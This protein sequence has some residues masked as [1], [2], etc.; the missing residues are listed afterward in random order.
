M[1]RATTQI[2]YLIGWMKNRAARF[3][4][5]TATWDSHVI[6]FW[7]QREPSAVNLSFF[8]FT[9][10]PFV[11]RKRRHTSLAQRDQHGIVT[12]HL[13][14]HKVQFRDSCR[15]S[16]LN[17]FW[18]PGV[19]PRMEGNFKNPMHVSEGARMLSY[20]SQQFGKPRKLLYDEESCKFSFL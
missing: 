13:T 8:A 16:S 15:R 14:K 12:K 6:R 1:T 11:P 9:R 5:E 7:R 20:R 4:V 18:L 19:T 17:W 2:N 3:L 10:K